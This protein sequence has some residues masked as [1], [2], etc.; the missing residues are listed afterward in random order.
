MGGLIMIAALVMLLAIGAA[1]PLTGAGVKDALE[2]TPPERY[3]LLIPATRDGWTTLCHRL[4]EPLPTELKPLA[5]ARNRKGK[6]LATC[7]Q[8]PR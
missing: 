7:W 8:T 1:K 6:G 3:P 5:A 4:Q 2:N